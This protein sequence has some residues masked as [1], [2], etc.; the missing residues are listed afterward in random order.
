LGAALALLG[1]SRPWE[2]WGLLWLSWKAVG[3]GRVGEGG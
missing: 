2:S 1:G 3:P